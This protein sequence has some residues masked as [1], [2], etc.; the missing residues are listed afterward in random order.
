MIS[1][2]ESFERVKGLFNI[3]VTPFTKGGSVDVEALREGVERVLALAYDGLLIGGTYGEFATMDV[4]ERVPIFRA[5]MDQVGDRVPV[6]LCTAHSD[7]RIIR[8]LTRFAGEL[9]GLPMVTAPYISEVNDRHIVSFFETVSSLSPTGIMIYNAPGIG[10]TLSPELICRL[11]DI[12]GVVALK[13][14]DLAPT[15]VDIL[16]GELQGKIRLLAASDLVLLGPLALGFDGVSSTNSCA[17]PELIHAI[18]HAIVDGDARQAG[19]L[20]RLWYPLRELARKHG[21]PQT[22]KAVMALR[23][24]KGGHVRPPL[25]DFD[26]AQLAEARRA[27][28]ALAEHGEASVSLA[29]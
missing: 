10:I 9:G 20:Q 2:A 4:D 19:R 12:D 1:R 22:T 25:L 16:S 14:G 21:Q 11:A 3:T 7:P 28:S 8:D 24:W 17:L 23:G 15:S 5:V 18:Y 6:L 27:L 13:Q 26:D 29:A